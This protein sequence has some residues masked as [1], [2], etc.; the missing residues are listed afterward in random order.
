ME[1]II[2]PVN[3]ITAVIV[4]SERM[5]N[6]EGLNIY[7]YVSENFGSFASICED[8]SIMVKSSS[9]DSG[10]GKHNAVENAK[11]IM[12]SLKADGFNDVEKIVC[13]FN[14]NDNVFDYLNQI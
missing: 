11:Y 12:E 6:T 4:R 9:E 10:W 3:D 5:V 1:K 2:V 7:K 8:K 14:Q 13:Y